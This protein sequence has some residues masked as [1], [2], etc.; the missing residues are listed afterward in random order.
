LVF[1]LNQAQGK[2]CEG[3][4]LLVDSSL[5]EENDASVDACSEHVD[6][7]VLAVLNK[8]QV[9][10]KYSFRIGS[11]LDQLLKDTLDVVF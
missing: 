8:C 1:L 7:V 10:G 9:E 3:R 4:L 6:K 5:V 2:S 11:G